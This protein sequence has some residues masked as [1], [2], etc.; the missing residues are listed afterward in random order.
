VK[1]RLNS[2]FVERF[3]LDNRLS[4][5]DLRALSVALYASLWLSVPV[6]LEVKIFQAHTPDVAVLDA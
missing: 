3:V 6:R 5:C 2:R 1:C 4:G